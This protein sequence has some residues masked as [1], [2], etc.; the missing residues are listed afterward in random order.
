MYRNFISF[1]DLISGFNSYAA[2]KQ[3]DNDFCDVL[4]RILADCFGVRILIMYENPD[5]NWLKAFMFFPNPTIQPALTAKCLTGSSNLV[6][7]FKR[8]LHYD[9]IIERKALPSKAI[10]RVIS[11]PSSPEHPRL[12]TDPCPQATEQPVLKKC[13]NVSPCSDVTVQATNLPC[14]AEHVCLSPT[15]PLEKS[16]GTPPP[17]TSQ[18]VPPKT[19]VRNIPEYFSVKTMTLNVNG[20]LSKFEGGS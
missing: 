5:K 18:M 19:P 3:F 11:T 20:F 2:T 1:D 12:P 8:D 10:K 14:L 4:P 7:F 16:V 17:S 15:R 9:A 6:I 13:R